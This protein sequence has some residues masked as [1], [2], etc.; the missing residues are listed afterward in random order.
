MYKDQSAEDGTDGYTERDRVSRGEEDYTDYE[1][2]EEHDDETTTTTTIPV[3]DIV[4]IQSLLCKDH[5][6]AFEGGCGQCTAVKAVV[7]PE[8]LQQL[9]VSSSAV[10]VILSEGLQGQQGHAA[11]AVVGS[12][13]VGRG[14]QEHEGAGG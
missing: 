10:D 4:D 5:G 12:C 1:S 11:P 9:N 7:K 2:D 8:L 13:Q 6:V 3:V 14:D